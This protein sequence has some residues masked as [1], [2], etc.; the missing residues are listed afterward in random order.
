MKNK[1]LISLSV[2]FAFLAL[3]ITGILLYIK[4]KAH[5]VEMTHTIFGLLFVGFAIFHII[6]NWASIVGYS[7]SRKSG[8]YQKEF[9]I[10][11]ISFIVILVAAATELLEPVAEAGRFLA[12]KRPPRAEM[13]SFTEVKTNE[14]LEGQSL[15]IL[16]EKSKE[17]E[18]P[19]MAI[20]VEDSAHNFVKNLYVPGQEAHM[21]ESEEEA[22]EGHFDMTPFS[23]TTLPTWA[24]KA[25][26]KTPL[27]ETETPKDN[28]V[29]K[30]K[31]TL[32]KDFY[33]MAEVKS[34]DKNEV[35]SA[36][37]NSKT[38]QLGSESGNLIKSGIVVVE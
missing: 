24:A 3:S 38:G 29:L 31:V 17:A 20:W 7:K 19:V 33:V 32:G 12:P 5:A 23:A 15:R 14:N 34:K 9:I 36:H 35:Y 22:R 8:S 18:L 1:N 13:L 6:N 28:F 10:A 30:T 21:P 25:T 26:D 11:G 27:T 4:Q 16:I 2:A 37:M